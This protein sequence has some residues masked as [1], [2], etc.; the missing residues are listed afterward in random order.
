MFGCCGSAAGIAVRKLSQGL[1]QH[2]VQKRNSKARS[3]S[4]RR[5]VLRN[6]EVEV[7]CE[8]RGTLAVVII[9]RLEACGKQRAP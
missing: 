4:L 2:V 3:I 5:I 9:T 1:C 6:G 8:T 7:I